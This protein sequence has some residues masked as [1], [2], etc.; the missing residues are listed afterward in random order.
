VTYI[1]MFLAAGTSYAYKVEAL[2]CAGAVLAVSGE[3]GA[4]ATREPA[5]R[6]ETRPVK[7]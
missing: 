4:G 2:N 7:R 5:S 1:D 3:T 6:R